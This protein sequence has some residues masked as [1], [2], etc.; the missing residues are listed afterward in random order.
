[1]VSLE[2]SRLAVFGGTALTYSAVWLLARWGYN[3]WLPRQD[4]SVTQLYSAQFAEHCCGILHGLVLGGAG[5]VMVN[6]AAV[7]D[8]VLAGQSPLLQPMAVV[9]ATYLL[10]DTLNLFYQQTLRSKPSHVWQDFFRFNRTMVVHHGATMIGFFTVAAYLQR[11]HYFMATIYMAEF[12]SVFLGVRGLLST[13]GL[14]NARLATVN[15]LIFMLVFFRFRILSVPLM[16]GDYAAALETT[17]LDL[18]LHRMH[19]ACFW[20]TIGFWALQMFWFQQMVSIL[21]NTLHRA[22]RDSTSAPE[23]SEKH[24]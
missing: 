7:R 24:D 10:G 1:M 18:L 19:R 14:K 11:A 13:L 16:I 21:F 2:F 5:Y 3:R 23:P 15:N 20:G 6:T 4:S 22:M 9:M 8:D 17:V 12:S